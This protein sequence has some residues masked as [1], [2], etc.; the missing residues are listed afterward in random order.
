MA[1]FNIIEFVLMD[2]LRISTDLLRDYSSTQEQL[3]YLILIPHA[4]MFLFIFIFADGLSR[5]AVP[6]PDAHRGFKVLFGIIA[7]ITLIFTG[8]Y[9]T[10]LLPIFIVW[11]KI[12][13]ISALVLFS[14]NAIMHSSMIAGLTR[15]AA[16]AGGSL[17][18]GAKERKVITKRLRVVEEQLTRIGPLAAGGGYMY[19]AELSRLQAEKAKLE[20]ELAA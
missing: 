3:V 8:W 5:M 12:V 10:I 1:A 2:L 6:G 14:L 20:A 11:W 15:V 19:T 7:Y 9:G 16:S 17:T 18:K 13:L 4:V